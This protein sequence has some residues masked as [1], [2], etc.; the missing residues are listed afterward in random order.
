LRAAGAGALNIVQGLGFAEVTYWAP[1]TWWLPSMWLAA[2]AV[3]TVWASSATDTL[4]AWKETAGLSPA[5]HN[6]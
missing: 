2:E 6:M 1:G 4:T 5:P 3:W